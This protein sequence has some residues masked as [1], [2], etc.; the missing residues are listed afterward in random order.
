MIASTHRRQL[1]HLA[2]QIPW[3]ERL[4]ESFPKNLATGSLEPSWTGQ[5]IP[6]YD[7][8]Q[9]AAAY[10]LPG[11]L[12]HFSC[13]V[14]AVVEVS[15]LKDQLEITQLVGDSSREQIVQTESS[16]NA[17]ARYLEPLSGRYSLPVHTKRAAHQAAKRTGIQ[18]SRSGQQK[19]CAEKE[20][21]TKRD[22]WG[23]ART[24]GLSRMTH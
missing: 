17:E 4:T 11:C 7:E 24:L 16:N 1:G 3:N 20:T 14:A 18:R 21:K 6:A 12:A 22:D 8:R 2:A 15:M 13:H 19:E 23:G 9:R 10:R 5:L